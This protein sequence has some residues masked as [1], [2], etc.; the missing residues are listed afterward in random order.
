VAY[1]RFAS[2]YRAFRDVEDLKEELAVLE[3]NR[4]QPTAATGQLPLLPA[5]A[6]EGL[7]QRRRR[8]RVTRLQADR[9]PATSG[10]GDRGRRP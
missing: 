5:E 6:L 2:V 10:G 3:Q 8:G 7:S 4:A 9:R 1:I